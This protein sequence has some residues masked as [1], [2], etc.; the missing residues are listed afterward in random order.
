MPMT[1]HIVKTTHI[2]E[3]PEIIVPSSKNDMEVALQTIT[4]R[5]LDNFVPDPRVPRDVRDEFVELRQ[6]QSGRI[7][8]EIA[9]AVMQSAEIEDFGETVA[10]LAAPVSKNVNRLANFLK[11]YEQH[12]ND[13]IA[14]HGAGQTGIVSYL[15]V[16]ERKKTSCEA[17]ESRHGRIFT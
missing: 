13:Y 10:S 4:D 1:K 6:L 9:E 17:C 7:A 15:F 14:I 11:V 5:F 12:F 2:R 16:C 3:G 8:G